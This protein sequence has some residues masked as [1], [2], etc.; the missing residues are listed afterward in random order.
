MNHGALPSRITYGVLVRGCETTILANLYRR[1]FSWSYL[2][3]VAIDSLIWFTDRRRQRRGWHPASARLSVT[4]RTNVTTT[5]TNPPMGICFCCCCDSSRLHKY[6][7]AMGGR[8]VM[9]IEQFAP[10]Y[11]YIRSLN[12]CTGLFILLQ[13]GMGRNCY[14]NGKRFQN[15]VG[16]GNKILK[17]NGNDGRLLLT[18]NFKVTWHKN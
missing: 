12:I 7:F 11:V 1:Q 10:C 2:M 6:K 14:R 9:V 17:N 5:P 15:R 8:A 3:T 4:Q 16:N 13:T 18:A